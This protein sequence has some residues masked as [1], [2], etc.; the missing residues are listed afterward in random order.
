MS[1]KAYYDDF[2]PHSG[3]IRER[4]LGIRLFDFLMLL[5]SAGIGGVMVMTYFVPY[6]NPG[7]V[8]FLPVLGLAAPAVYVATVLLMLYWIIRWRR[9]AALTMLA[10]VFVGLFSVSLFW[11]PEFRRTYGDEAVAERGTFLFMT[12]NVRGFYDEKGRSSVDSVVALI[13]RL[14]PDIV[15]LQEFNGRLADRSESFRILSDG[16][17]CA[18]FGQTAAPDS[19]EGASMAILSKYRILRTATLLTPHSSV[20]ADV[21]IDED[22]VRIFNNHL[23]STAIKADDNDFITSHRILSDTAREVKLRSI[24]NRLRENSELRAYQVDSIAAVVGATRNPRI[25]CGDF[26]DTPVSY[27]YRRMSEGLED[28]FSDC[29]SG[30]SYTYR[31]FFN[32][33]RIDFVLT[34]PEFRAVSYDVPP[35]TSSDH[36]PV[37]VRVKRLRKAR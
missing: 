29:G 8:W 13:G 12:Y 30:Y 14:D 33:L 24:V 27:V 3:Q 7:R 18:R 15:C 23:R 36:L 1:D 37:V 16:Y 11:R 10:I 28:A 5:C 21:L 20:W 4:G 2:G 17:E 26:N 31:G 9:A 19:L 22:T 25:V 6:V 32:M 34:S 35:A